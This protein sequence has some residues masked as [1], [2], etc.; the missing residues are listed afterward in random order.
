VTERSLNTEKRA[1]T[2][3]DDTAIELRQGDALKLRVKGHTFKE[4]AQK[5]SISVGQAHADVQAALSDVREDV[6][7]D[8]AT[9]RKLQLKRLD[10][11]M[12]VADGILESKSNGLDVGDDI[13]SAEIAEELSRLEEIKLKA[14]D[15]IVKL[16]ERRAKL[17]GLDAPEKREIDARVAGVASPEEAARLVREKFGE[18]AAKVGDGSAGA[19]PD[20][21]SGRDSS[22]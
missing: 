11:A 3:A 4:I 13:D 12:V 17:L 18:H 14:I 21:T 9:E 10:K 16:E 6:A 1:Y 19:L 20:T 15:R 7:R 5:L 2:V 8:A 22:A